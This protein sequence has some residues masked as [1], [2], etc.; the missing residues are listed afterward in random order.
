[1]VPETDLSAHRS[2]LELGAGE[3]KSEDDDSD[4]EPQDTYNRADGDATLQTVH[5]MQSANAVHLVP[6]EAADNLATKGTK[7]NRRAL[8]VRIVTTWYK[9]QWLSTHSCT[10]MV[11]GCFV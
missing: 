5:H 4:E 9:V 8:K 2:D 10:Y 6:R 1:V 11:N 7:R 3:D